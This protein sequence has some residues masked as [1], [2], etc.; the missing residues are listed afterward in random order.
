MRMALGMTQAGR[1]APML[2]EG[3]VTGFQS[4]GTA[5]STG[6][7][8][9]LGR[10]TPACRNHLAPE[11]KGLWHRDHRGI[12]MGSRPR[13]ARL[14][15]GEEEDVVAEARHRLEGVG[16]EGVGAGQ[17]KRHDRAGWL[18]PGNSVGAD[19]QT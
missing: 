11:L 6:E 17:E 15:V 13:R 3:S 7:G 14:P 5:R 2:T 18:D 16:P 1:A 9:A 8:P 4:A 19:P 12:R 10:G